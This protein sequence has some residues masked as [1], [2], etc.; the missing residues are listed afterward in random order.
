VKRTRAWNV[1]FLALEVGLAGWAHVVAE[2]AW[3]TIGLTFGA[4]I[5]FGVA[6][7]TYT[8]R[9][10]VPRTLRRHHA[11]LRA[12]VTA[13]TAVLERRHEVVDRQSTPQFTEPSDVARL[14]RAR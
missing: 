1:A 14:S 7:M 3:T 10:H 11:L 12:H 9:V 2:V 8:I 13:P 5:A 6:L 4:V